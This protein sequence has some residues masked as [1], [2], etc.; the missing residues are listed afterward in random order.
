IPRGEGDEATVEFFKL[1]KFVS[2]DNLAIEYQKRGLDPADP[3]TLVAVNEADPA[4]ADKYPNITHWQDKN[5]NWCYIA[6]YRYVGGRYVGVGR[7]AYD[8][9]GLWWFGG[10]RKSRTLG[11]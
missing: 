1:G 10:V 5:G 2:D 7:D 6:F 11:N 3:Y 8:W 9:G 4:F